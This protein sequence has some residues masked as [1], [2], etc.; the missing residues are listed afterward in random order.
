MKNKVHL[1]PEGID[2]INSIKVGMNTGRDYCNIS[3]MD[4][5]SPLS[6]AS[7]KSSETSSELTKASQDIVTESETSP[8]L[9]RR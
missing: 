8:S 9:T 1:T 3:N 5:S 6:S 2:K 7:E 4:S